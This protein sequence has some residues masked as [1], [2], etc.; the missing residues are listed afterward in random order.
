MNDDKKKSLSRVHGG[1]TGRVVGSTLGL[2]IEGKTYETIKQIHGYINDFV[3]IKYNKEGVFDGIINDDELYEIILLLA[4]RKKGK[5]L[6]MM[7]VARE[8]L[9]R[10]EGFR[11]VFTAERVALERFKKGIF[12]FG[13]NLIP[14]NDFYDYIG[15]Q[16]R[17]EMPGWIHPGDIKSAVDLAITDASVSHARDGIAGE[18]FVSALVSGAFSIPDE[19]VHGEYVDENDLHE[20]I[21]RATMAIPGRGQYI[22]VLDRVRELYTARPAAWERNFIEFRDY[23][24]GD[25]FDG[26]YADSDGKRQQELLKSYFV[27]VLPNAGIIMLALLHSG[28]SF[29]EALKISAGCG[30]DTDCNCGNIGGI[31]GTIIGQE[32]IPDKWKRPINNTFLTLVRG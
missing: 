10:L 23:V 27:H 17:G 20:L 19:H 2:P 13:E 16:M 11:F 25:L 8:W 3:D 14:G 24:E 15:A 28:G 32:N 7:D 5:N 29:S 9:D 1:F 30:M 31:F 26:L 22:Q 6:T 21:E 18:A 12:L 4:L